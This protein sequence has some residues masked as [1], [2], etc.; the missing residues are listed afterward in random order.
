MRKAGS[1][2][3]MLDT[4]FLI[5][6]L[7][8][9]DILHQNAMEYFR[10]FL[11]QDVPMYVS[12]ITVA[13]YCVNGE[14]AELPFRNIRIVPFNIQHA[15]VAG[16]FASVLYAARATGT[17]VVDSRLIIPNDAKIFAQASCLDDV[18]YFVTSDTK[19]AK[20][21]SK[22]SDSEDVSFSHMDIH[23]PFTQQF[24]VLDI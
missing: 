12:T 22:I 18:R 10:Y 14:I 6:L 24:G 7:S 21:I 16:R 1:Y 5:R 17:L 15:P 4:S 23:I 20:L 19:S 9:N 8:K 13:E 2:S 11:E 3:V